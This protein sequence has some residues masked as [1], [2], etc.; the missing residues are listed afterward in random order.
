MF[1]LEHKKLKLVKRTIDISDTISQPKRLS[2]AAK[3]CPWQILSGKTRSTRTLHHRMAEDVTVFR[4]R[5]EEVSMER[6][7]KTLT[8]THEF[9][10]ITNSVLLK[11]RPCYLCANA[12][13]RLDKF[14][15]FSY[16]AVNQLPKK[17][18]CFPGSV[19]YTRP[20]LSEAGCA[21]YKIPLNIIS[22]NKEFS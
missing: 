16:I 8:R 1:L 9:D 14:V 17:N 22:Q 21:G 5:G 20:V 15:E 18:G 6:F 11:D 19:R 2:K 13:K 10:E 7:C 12:Q 4:T 3:S